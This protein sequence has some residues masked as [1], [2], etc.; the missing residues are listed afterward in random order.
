MFFDFNCFVVI[1]G[2]TFLQ[3]NAPKKISTTVE[4][5]LDVLVRLICSLSLL[6]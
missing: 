2:H 3:L 6:A 4:L 5:Y 1:L